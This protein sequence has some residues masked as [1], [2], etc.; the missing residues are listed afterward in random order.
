[1]DVCRYLSIFLFIHP[2][3]HGHYSENDDNEVDY[4]V[5]I[6]NSK[7]VVRSIMNLHFWLEGRRS[8]VLKVRRATISEIPYLCFPH[9]GTSQGKTTCTIKKRLSVHLDT[10]PCGHKA[11]QRHFSSFIDTVSDH[12]SCIILFI[13]IIDFI[14]KGTNRSDPLALNITSS[15]KLSSIRITHTRPQEAFEPS[16]TMWA[17]T[18]E[19][20]IGHEWTI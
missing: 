10:H 7:N 11:G 2:T 14:V 3:R 19:G 16:L 18:D 8:A 20:S 4:V 1:M 9:W 15:F 17:P 13:A 12:M 6:N 5:D